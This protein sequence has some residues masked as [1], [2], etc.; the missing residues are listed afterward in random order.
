[1]DRIPD[2]SWPVIW[3]VDTEGTSEIPGMGPRTLAD[4]LRDLRG[5]RTQR[6]AARR[7]GVSREQWSAW[8]CRRRIPTPRDVEQIAEAF[9]AD[10]DELQRLTRREHEAG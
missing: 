4:E 7:A 9:G 6:Y 8:E 10:L 5:S 2:M 3:D 1:M